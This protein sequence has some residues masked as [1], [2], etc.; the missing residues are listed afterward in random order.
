MNSK[1]SDEHTREAAASAIQLVA[2]LDR[3]LEVAGLEAK[4]G[5]LA[6]CRGTIATCRKLLRLMEPLVTK[7]V[8][9][10]DPGHAPTQA[11]RDQFWRDE[12]VTFTN[13]EGTQK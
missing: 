5:Q 2:E 8:G 1:P 7:A 13:P 6:S 3:G 4:A 9:P 11:E 12:Q 10:P